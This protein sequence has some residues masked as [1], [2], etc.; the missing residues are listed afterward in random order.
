MQFDRPLLAICFSFG[1]RE[2]H[3]KEM[4]GRREFLCNQKKDAR[5]LIFLDNPLFFI[6]KRNIYLNIYSCLF[7][8]FFTF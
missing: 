3:K 5:G 6:L 7:K 1:V 2:I 4:G 8:N